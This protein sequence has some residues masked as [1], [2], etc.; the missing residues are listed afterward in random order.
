VS[1]LITGEA[2]ELNVQPAA[3]AARALSCLID[4]IVYSLVNIGLL[5]AM[6][7]L[8]LKVLDLNGLLLGSLM[9]V[10]TIFVFVLLP[11]LVE[12][13]SHGRSLGKLI[14]GLRV[15]RDDGG[16]VRLRHSFIR[17]L[18]WPFEIVSSG[19]GIAALS[20][21]LS[22]QAKRLGDY[23]AGTIAV[24]E[25]SRPLPPMQTHVA[26]HLQDWLNRTD[27]TSIPDGLHRRIVQFLAMAPQ[28]GAESRWQR[29]IELATELN[30]YVAPAPPEGTFPEQFLSAV[31]HRQRIAEVEKQ[32]RRT[33][34]ANAFRSGVDTL[35]FGL[36][37]TRR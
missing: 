16:A 18:L 12:V 15:V 3:L 9:T 4:Y 21:L 6:F 10:M 31:I 37:L 27:V 28:L 26:P 34:R 2:V 29:A 36:S 1:T 22:P 7:W 25:R 11:M 23:L 32:R 5:V 30:P 19:G 24:S 33:D 13:L 17:A 20:G 35:P 14:L 8:M